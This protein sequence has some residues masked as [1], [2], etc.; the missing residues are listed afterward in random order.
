MKE[1]FLLA[2]KVNSNSFQEII[3]LL[4]EHNG[5]I[6]FMS[7]K[8]KLQFESNELKDLGYFAQASKV[9]NK[10]KNIPTRLGSLSIPNSTL[11]LFIPKSNLKLSDKLGKAAFTENSV[12]FIESKNII[13]MD[14]KDYVPMYAN[15]GV[16]EIMEYYVDQK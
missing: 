16:I 6:N 10:Y 8:I 3:V 15:I 13:L 7:E 9:S 2:D 5:N 14:T 11:D 1:I 12:E 4:V